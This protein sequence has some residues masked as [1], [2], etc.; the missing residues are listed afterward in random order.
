MVADHLSRLE[1]P[2]KGCEIP[3]DDYFKGE[4]LL[5]VQALTPWYADY[6]NYLVCGVLTPD[7]TYQQ[8]KKFFSDIKHY[9]WEEP[10]LYK[11][12]G[13]G[14]IRR[15]LP[16]DKFQDVLTHYHSLEYGGH[17]SSIKTTAKV[18]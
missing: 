13:D 8:K 12:C 18:L 6:V 2:E 4:Q 11:Q 17:F 9:Y 16:E 15:C 14:L 10:L 1:L 7:L 3:I 5:Q